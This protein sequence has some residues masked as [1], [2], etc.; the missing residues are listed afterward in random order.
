MDEK[1]FNALHPTKTGEVNKKIIEQTKCL[2][3]NNKRYF[4]AIIQKMT[5]ERPESRKNAK[6]LLDE[7]FK[8]D[9]LY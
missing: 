7:I 1:N 4:K 2:L 3:K 6:E 9:E 8:D 5:E